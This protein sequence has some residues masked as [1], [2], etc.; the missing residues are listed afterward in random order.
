MCMILK[1]HTNKHFFTD[2]KKKSTIIFAIMYLQ[3]KN[4]VNQMCQKP[5]NL[6]FKNFYNVLIFLQCDRNILAIFFSRRCLPH[7]NSNTMFERGNSCWA[8]RTT[9]LRINAKKNKKIK[10]PQLPDCGRLKNNSNSSQFTISCITMKTA[11]TVQFQ[12]CLLTFEAKLICYDSWGK[13]IKH[14]ILLFN[15]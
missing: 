1:E 15:L 12:L 14:P 8:K 11:W 13:Y 3:C 9:E 10:T 7:I 2:K 5:L 4:S 6:F